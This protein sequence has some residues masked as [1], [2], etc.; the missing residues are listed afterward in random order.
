M[1]FIKITMVKNVR[2]LERDITSKLSRTPS[3]GNKIEP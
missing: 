2:M 1:T 3:N